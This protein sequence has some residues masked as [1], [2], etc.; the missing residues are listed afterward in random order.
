MESSLRSLDLTRVQSPDLTRVQSPDLGKILKRIHNLELL[1]TRPET[2]ENPTE[3][4]EQHPVVGEA[5]PT[6][7]GTVTG[8]LGNTREDLGHLLNRLEVIHSD[9]DLVS[10]KYEG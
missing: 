4:Q 7:K 2:S 9:F 6:S 3:Y 10:S 8:N 1:A 5:F